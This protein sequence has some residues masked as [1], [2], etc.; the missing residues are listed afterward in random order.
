MVEHY[1]HQ[2]LANE[3]NKLKKQV[4]SLEELI[5]QTRDK[6][7]KASL[8][9]QLKSLLLSIPPHP[10]SSDHLPP[11]AM[12]DSRAKCLY[13][14][15]KAKEDEMMVE[16]KLEA[17]MLHEVDRLNVLNLLKVFEV[18]VTWSSDRDDCMVKDDERDKEIASLRNENTSL[19]QQVIFFLSRPCV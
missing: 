9:S 5:N 7:A 15:L 18:E 6:K 11:I 19:Q 17:S 8:T 12:I 14:G 3:Y 16:D 2:R 4:S 13:D 1:K 10:P